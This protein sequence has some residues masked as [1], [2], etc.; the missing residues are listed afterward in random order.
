MTSW[1][2]FVKQA[3]TLSAYTEHRFS[4][5]ATG[6]ITYIATVRKDGG[7]RVH[8]VKVFPAGSGL[9]LFMY[10]ESPKGLDLQRDPR[11]AMHAAVTANPFESGELAAWGSTAIVTD[12][13]VRA[14]ATAAAPFASPPPADN[15]LYEIWLEM[16]IGTPVLDGKPVHLRWRAVDGVEEDIGFG[17]RTS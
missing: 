3:P 13:K 4:D 11:I 5:D 15:V 1:V 16:V 7:P 14:L 9:Y 17:G 8:P 12:P 10:P 6:R 2:D